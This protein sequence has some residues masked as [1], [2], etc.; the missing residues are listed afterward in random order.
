M[1]PADRPSGTLDFAVNAAGERD[2]GAM[3]AF[4]DPGGDDADDTLVPGRIEETESVTVAAY[5]ALGAVRC[6]ILRV[7]FDDA[8]FDIECVKLP[9]DLHGAFGAVGGQAFDPER[10]IAQPARGVQP[11]RERKT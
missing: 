2:N 6:G 3:V 8:E 7:R 10:H 9:R 1:Q 4:L 11:R 5:H